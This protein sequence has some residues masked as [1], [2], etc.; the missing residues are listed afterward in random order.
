MRPQHWHVH[1][2]QKNGRNP[3]DSGHAWLF[4]CGAT[5]DRTPDLCI[6]NAALSQLSYRP[7]EQA[8]KD[9]GQRVAALVLRVQNRAQQRF[10]DG[11]TPAFQGCGPAVAVEQGFERASRGENAFGQSQPRGLRSDHVL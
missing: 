9:T 11:S 7:I 5:G 8:G 3:V 4:D 1:V 6:A 2:R 10:Q